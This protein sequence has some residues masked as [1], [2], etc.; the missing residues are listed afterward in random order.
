MDGRPHL[1]HNL[2]LSSRFLHRY[3]LI[4]FGDRDLEAQ[5]TGLDLVITGLGL[6][7][8]VAS[9]SSSLACWPR[10]LVVFE[11]LL[12]CFVTLTLKI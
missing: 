9:V 4:L 10:G 1:S 5:K 11:V 12:K 7:T 6:M 8:V 3:Q 2:P